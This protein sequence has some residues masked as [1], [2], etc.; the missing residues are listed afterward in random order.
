MSDGGDNVTGASIHKFDVMQTSSNDSMIASSNI[1]WPVSLSV[2]EQGRRLYWSDSKLNTISSCW[3]DGSN[4]RI[5][6]VFHDLRPHIIT[7]FGDF[8]FVTSYRTN[9]LVRI[10]KLSNVLPSSNDDSLTPLRFP[11]FPIS[12]YSSF[13]V[14]WI[15]HSS[16]KP[17]GILI[18]YPTTFEASK[19]LNCRWCSSY[20]SD[21]YCM[22]DS[23]DNFS[24][25]C[26]NATANFTSQ[27]LAPCP[28]NGVQCS[29][30]EVCENGACKCDGV[31]NNVSTNSKAL[32]VIPVVVIIAIILLASYK[33]IYKR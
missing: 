8:I 23:N 11:G 24:C 19:A 21:G 9:A 3:F 17:Q 29:D 10:N 12:D 2:D 32:W 30:M 27:R 16:A 22:F 5:V 28:C 4:R 13:D 26:A 14:S 7:L 6:H 1:E 15:I 20:Q 18:L 33:F 31:C 25:M